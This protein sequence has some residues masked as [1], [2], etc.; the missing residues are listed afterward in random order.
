M[1]VFWTN[2]SAVTKGTAYA[3]PSSAGLP[4][5]AYVIGI[6]SLTVAPLATG[7]TASTVSPVTETG[8]ANNT[9]APSAG[10]VSVQTASQELV[11]G[12]DLT[13][14]AVVIANLIIAGEGTMNP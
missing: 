12:D 7:G 13:A 9:A 10:N 8:V 3:I 4:A 5:N 2:T 6:R 1:V 14:D 11:S